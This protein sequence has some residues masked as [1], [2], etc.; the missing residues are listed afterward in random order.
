VTGDNAINGTVNKNLRI[1]KF[2]IKSATWTGRHWLY[3]LEPSST[4]IG[5]MTAINDHQFLVIERN[6]ATA[7]DGGTPFELRTGGL[8]RLPLS[9]N[10]PQYCVYSILKFF[11]V[12]IT[13]MFRMTSYARYFK[14]GVGPSRPN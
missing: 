5:D 4:N 12:D 8:V 3:Q 7:T 1:N 9:Q 11:K 10:C 13:G 6:G 2:D 14:E